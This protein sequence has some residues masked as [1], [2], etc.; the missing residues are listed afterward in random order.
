MDSRMSPIKHIRASDLVNFKDMLNSGFIVR[1]RSGLKK[2][3]R[4][5]LF[6][7][8]IV[9]GT[10]FLFY[11]NSWVGA[12]GCVVVGSIM[13]DLGRTLERQ[14]KLLETA[15]F[16]NAIFSSALGKRHAF[17]VLVRPDGGIMFLSRAFQ[18]A[19]PEFIEQPKRDLETL[20]TVIKVQDDIR[21]NIISMVSKN[22]ES[23]VPFSM[24]IGADKAAQSMNL[25]IE[26]VA[27]PTGFVLLCAQ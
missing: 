2:I 8:V 22:T 19:F 23:V 27:R 1:R 26:P 3:Y 25:S 4:L 5:C 10:A 6:L 14:Q 7:L 9:L 18:E 11:S 20:L 13:L 15:E 17:F 12:M 21:R 24:G 16:M